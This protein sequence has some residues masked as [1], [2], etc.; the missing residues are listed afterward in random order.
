MAVFDAKSRYVVPPVIPYE[1]VD[2]RGRIVRAVPTPEPPIEISAGVHVRREGQQLDQLAQGYLADA[3][4]YWRIAEL[5]GAIVPDAL[6]ERE[7]LN[8]PSPIR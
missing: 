2:A 6:D 4:A 5:N 3:H 1:V 8:I 7:T